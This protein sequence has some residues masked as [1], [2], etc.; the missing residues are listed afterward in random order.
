LTKDCLV[1]S[2]NKHLEIWN[3]DFHKNFMEEVRVTNKNT[4]KK[5]LGKVNFFSDEDEE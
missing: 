2:I 1:V 4:H 3:A 5:L